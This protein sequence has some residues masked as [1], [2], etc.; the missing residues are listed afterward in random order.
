MKLKLKMVL[1]ELLHHSP[2][3]KYFFPSPIHSFTSAQ[4]CFLCKC[5]EDTKEVNG[6]IIEVG[7]ESGST[8]LFL[9]DYMDTQRIEKTYYAIDSF[10]GFVVEDIDYEINRRGKIKDYFKS[11]RTNKKKWFDGTMKQANI[12][13]VFSIEADAN[14]FDFLSLGAFSFVLLDVDLYR[15]TLKCLRQLYQALSPGGLIVVDDCSM[16]DI[17]YDGADQAY[18]EFMKEINQPAHIVYEKLGIIKK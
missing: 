18:K 4:L 1:K 15:P 9:N 10:A 13:S 2:L 12:C 3:R 17:R 16:M 7:C 11:F 5:I 6:A 14:Q 8:T